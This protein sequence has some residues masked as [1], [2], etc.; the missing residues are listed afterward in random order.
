MDGIEDQRPLSRIEKNF[1]KILKQHLQKLL[2]AKRMYWRQRATVRRIKFGDENTKFFQA[3]ATMRLRSN[4][5]SQL[6]LKLGTTVTDHSMKANALWLSFKNRLGVTECHQ[7]LFYLQELIQAVNLPV[8]DKPFSDDEIKQVLKEMPS[9]HAPG[10]DGFNGNFLKKCWHL[11]EPD[12]KR[13]CQQ[14][15]TG[16]LGISS[17]NG[18]FITL[19]PKKESP[20]PINYE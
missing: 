6:T 2:Q 7:M 13:L 17:I 14:F 16:N 10:P 18:S 20:K 4:K 8:L 5:I 12:F 1:R 11:I 15:A 19:T 3:V 9:D